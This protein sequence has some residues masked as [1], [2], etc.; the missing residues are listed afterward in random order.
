MGSEIQ[1][2]AALIADNGRLLI[3][4]RRRDAAF[5]LKW[6]FPGGK[7]KPGEPPEA[8]LRRELEEELGVQAAVG[9]LVFEHTHRYAEPGSKSI[10]CFITR[11]WRTRRR[12]TWS[13]RT[14]SGSSRRGSVNS[15]SLQ[16]ICQSSRNW[17]AAAFERRKPPFAKQCNFMRRAARKSAMLT[18][19][20]ARRQ[21]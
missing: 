4:Q 20:C 14:C 12:A 9:A 18:P 3:C 16:A 5:P 2:V 6:E 10:C 13:L 15:I 1:V 8:A 11:A 17:P 19:E 7:V 21:L